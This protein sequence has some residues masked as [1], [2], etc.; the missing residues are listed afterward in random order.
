MIYLKRNVLTT[1]RLA[2]SM[3]CLDLPLWV[4]DPQVVSW[5]DTVFEEEPTVQMVE[6][7]YAELFPGEVHS[8][9]VVHDLSSLNKYTNEYETLKGKLED[10]MDD[11]IS[12]RRR[13]RKIKRKKVWTCL[14]CP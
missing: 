8:V 4:I 1:V 6:H 9:H 12:K 14:Q 13:H 3:T 11:Y 5:K 10:L 2:M 7:E